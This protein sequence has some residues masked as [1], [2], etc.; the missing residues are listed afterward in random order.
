MISEGGGEKSGYPSLNIVEV[1]YDTNADIVRVVV[2]PEYD[3]MDI[4]IRTINRI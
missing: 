3:K 1:T 4:V 2:S